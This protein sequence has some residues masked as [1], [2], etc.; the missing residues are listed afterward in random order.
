MKKTAASISPTTEMF[1][2]T[3]PWIDATIRPLK[4]AEAA[5]EAAAPTAAPPAPVTAVAA[6]NFKEHSIGK[7]YI[8]F[9]PRTALCGD[10]SL[11]TVLV[12]LYLKKRI[13]K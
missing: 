10:F 6:V 11:Q 12:G 9:H 7:S 1:T 8:N 3:T 13:D 4:A 2:S 5:G